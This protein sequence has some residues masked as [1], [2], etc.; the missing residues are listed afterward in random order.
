MS[1][2]FKCCSAV[3]L[4]LA[5]KNNNEEEILL[6]KRKNT[7]YCDGYYDLPGG[8]L[9]ANEDIFDGMIR[10]AKEEIGITIKRE[11]MEILHIYHRY[12]NSMLKFVFSVKKYE[13]TPINN[14]PDKCEKIEWV[15]IDNLPEMVVPTIRIELENIKNGIYYSKEK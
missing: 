1:E 12:K 7:G 13:G 3:M 14:E 15:E 11:D 8:H 9:E 6:Q 2:R 4:L 10:E 5:R